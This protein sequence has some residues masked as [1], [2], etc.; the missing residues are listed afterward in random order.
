MEALGSELG[1]D[2]RKV[3]DA[4]RL[5]VIDST[6][7]TTPEEG[8]RYWEETLGQPAVGGAPLVRAIG[9]MSCERPLFTSDA[10]MIRFEYGF[11]PV[12]K[13]F[14]IISIC[15]YDVRVFSAKTVFDA[16]KAHTD[17][18]PFRIGSFL[19]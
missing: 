19:N 10:E 9:E 13:R 16:I 14:P 7:D 4:G 5:V 11:N 2:M 3:V 12:A 6:S 8:L 1:L 15:L 17:L 18:Y